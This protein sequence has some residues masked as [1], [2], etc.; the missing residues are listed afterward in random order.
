MRIKS[1]KHLYVNSMR[2]YGVSIIELIVFI[3]VIS[4]AGTAL[5]KSFNFSAKHNADPLI[6]V[7]ALEAAQSKLDE[8]LALKYDAITPTGGIPACSSLDVGAIACDNTTDGDMND[9]DDFNGYHDV[10]YVGYTRDVV[11]TLVTLP[12]TAPDV[13]K[14]VGAADASV[15]NDAKL[16]TVTVTGPLSTSISLAVFRANF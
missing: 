4:V 15:A 2:Q 11:V 3:V 16:I 7:R 1:Y 5:F 6:Q 8:I 13:V 12:V 14:S 9:V 10:P